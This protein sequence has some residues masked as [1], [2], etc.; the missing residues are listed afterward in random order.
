MTPL[1]LQGW[2]RQAAIAIASLALLSYACLR[3]QLVWYG[4]RIHK[5]QEALTQLR[6][7]VLDVVE[8]KELQATVQAQQ[9]FAAAVKA[10]TVDWE[11]VLRGL[12]CELPPSVVV[13]TAVING[14]RVALHGVLRYP[15][16]APEE[17]LAQIATQ[18][19]VR[20]VFQEVTVAF[21]PP[22][23]DDPTLARVDFTGRL[24][25]GGAG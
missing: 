11:K 17:Y 25:S 1:R 19:K 7:A 3:I 18:L 10:A 6:P 16:P 8:A 12:A 22:D 24:H 9:Q 23:P 2:R 4:H 21:T 20:G 15:P 13:H 14:S 5:V